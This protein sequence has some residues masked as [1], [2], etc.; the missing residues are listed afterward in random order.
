MTKMLSFLLALVLFAPVAVSIAMQA[1][2]I[3]T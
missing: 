1:T 3:V 2:R